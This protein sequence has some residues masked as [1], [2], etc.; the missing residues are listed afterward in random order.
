[1]DNKVEKTI[2]KLRE[3]SN[4][5]FPILSVYLGTTG[6]KTPIS[7]SISSIFHSLIHQTLGEEEWKKFR[8]DIRRVDEYLK[9]AYDSRGNRSIAFF[10]ADKKLWEILE[11]EFY[12]PPL[13]TVSYS[14]YIQPIIE[15]LDE[16]KPY[17]VLLADREKARLFTV[18]LGEMQEHKNVLD[19][20]VPQ[21]VKHGD[22]TWDQQGKIMRHIEDHLHRHLK[23]IARETREFAKDYPVSFVIIGGHKDII[24]KVKKHLTYPLNKLVLGEFVTELNIPLNEVFLHSKEIAQG[25]NTGK[26]VENE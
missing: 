25:I 9:T 16:Y 15:A 17:L 20:Q 2:K 7:S 22:D 10:T 14:P 21:R 18:Y 19:G 11:F 3:F 12:L 13:C 6:T 23:L 1:M 4:S 5:P 8:K 26:G 24:P